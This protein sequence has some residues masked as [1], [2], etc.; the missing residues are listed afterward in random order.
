[1]GDLA[2]KDRVRVKVRGEWIAVEVTRLPDESC[3][4]W[5][6]TSEDGRLVTWDASA[7]AE[8]LHDRIDIPL[9]DAVEVVK[10]RTA[11]VGCGE[12]IAE[13]EE[14]L[15][16]A[17]GE[18]GMLSMSGYGHVITHLRDQLGVERHRSGLVRDV[19]EAAR[20][21]RVARC[22]RAPTELDRYCALEKA[23]DVLIEAEKA[24][25]DE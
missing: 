12:R 25:R 2:V 23:I 13:L 6:G 16:E 14:Q 4:W 15:A 3:A 19:V 22:L 5:A 11:C 7:D 10:R 9:A 8:P 18:I 17:R 24:G 21:W 1:M 20:C